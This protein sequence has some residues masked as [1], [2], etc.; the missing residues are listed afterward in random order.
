MKHIDILSAAIFILRLVILITRVASQSDVIEY[1][2]EQVTS[3]E[4]SKTWT[5]PNENGSGCKCGDSLNEVVYCSHS[6]LEVD[7]LVC[8]CMTFS[9]IFNKTVVGY[10]YFNCDF[11][12]YF[13]VAIERTCKTLNRKGQ[14]CGKCLD[15]YSPPIYSYSSKCVECKDYTYNWLKYIAVAFLPLTVVYIVVIVFK[16][17]VTSGKLNAYILI[18]QM[19]AAPFLIRILAFYYDTDEVFFNTFSFFYK[20]WNLDIFRGFYH[21]FCLHPKISILHTLALEY[22]IAIY[23][24][25]LIIVTYIFYKLHYHF[26]IVVTLW[27]PFYKCLACIRQE[28]DLQ[29]SLIGAFATFILLSYVK[30]VNIS[31]NLLTPVALYDVTGAQLPKL[32]VFYDGTYEYFGKD[33]RP[34]ACLALFMFLTFNIFPLVLLGVYP[35]RCFHK[36]LNFFRFRFQPLHIFMDTFTGCYKLEPYDCRHFAAFYL[37][38]RI[39]NLTLFALTTS[40]MYYPLTAIMYIITAFI[41]ATVRPYKNDK[42]NTLDSAFFLLFAIVCYGIPAFRFVALVDPKHVHGFW[43]M[44]GLFVLFLP[45]LYGAAL[46]G[47]HVI[48]KRI[49][50]RFKELIQQCKQKEIKEPRPHRLDHSDEYP[51]LLPPKE[52]PHTI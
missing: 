38:F 34:Y 23:P 10:C 40:P 30:I 47:Y 1:Y 9:D 24:L 48:P 31:F 22:V 44:Y 8:H 52:L 37:L 35:C 5:V 36:C 27:R 17:T 32:F 15:G 42:L 41:V 29:N 4:C 14:M 18:S 33:H 51:P 20:I 26:S 50:V 11:L 6:T 13:H 19:T 43:Y 45:P 49:F 16:I 2:N 25:V 12:D 39:I 3:I 21:P 46:A 28:W 7:I